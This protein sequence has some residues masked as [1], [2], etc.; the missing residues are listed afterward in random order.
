MGAVDAA[1]EQVQIAG[2]PRHV[3]GVAGVVVDDVGRA[4]VVQR[5]EPVRWEI[6]GGA[7]EA[8]E[9][10]L[11]GLA[12]EVR[13]E[14][15]LAVEPLALTGVYQNMRLGPVALVFLCRRLG[16]RERLSD[17]TRDWR[18]LA[19]AELDGLMPP[20]WST[21]VTDALDAW[22]ALQSRGDSPPVPVRV[23]DGHDLIGG[24][25]GSDGS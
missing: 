18:W 24:L 5:R 21:R 13:E 15:G 10:L 12:R 11:D 16:G 7:L 14:V 25:G 23:H 17:E 8:G 22:Q 6:P 19:R 20:A 4:L 1:A 9:R 3:L 2:L